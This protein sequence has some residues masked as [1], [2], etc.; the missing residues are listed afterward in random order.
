MNLK[1]WKTLNVIF[2]WRISAFSLYTF[3]FRWIDLWTWLLARAK[4][5]PGI[6]RPLVS[7]T[8]DSIS[9][10]QWHYVCNF[11]PFYKLTFFFAFFLIISFRVGVDD[12]RWQ[13]RRRNIFPSNFAQIQL[14]DKF[15]ISSRQFGRNCEWAVQHGR[16]FGVRI[17]SEER[18]F[19]FT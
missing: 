11:C 17:T 16:W 5:S 14:D 10:Q 7:V 18:Q 12:G 2:K 6:S 4:S 15:P 19:L 3:P 1:K 9:F 13:L 8:F